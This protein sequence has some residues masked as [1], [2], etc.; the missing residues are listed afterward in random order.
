M[1]FDKNLISSGTLNFD[2]RYSRIG[3]LFINQLADSII[4]R[5]HIFV[6]TLGI[7]ARL[8]ALNDAEPEPYGMYFM[9]QGVL[10]LSWPSLTTGVAR[11]IRDNYS[12][13]TETAQ[14]TSRTTMRTRFYTLDPERVIRH[15]IQNIQVIRIEIIVILRIRRRRRYNLTYRC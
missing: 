13:M 1:N 6:I 14:N 5:K 3:K 12:H 15:N 4:F 11:I 7:P 9:S 10:L 2:A 8:P